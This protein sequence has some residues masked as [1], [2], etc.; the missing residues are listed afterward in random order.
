MCPLPSWS[1]QIGKRDLNQIVTSTRDKT[2]RIQ[3]KLSRQTFKP[4][5]LPP[6][7]PEKPPSG[8]FFCLQKSLPVQQGPAPNASPVS[9]LPC[10]PH[11]KLGP[12]PLGSQ[13]TLLS[14]PASY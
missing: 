12:R 14:L 1:L 8:S 3:P 6:H 4:L 10:C 11:L 2:D 5:L 13:G 9:N 7:L